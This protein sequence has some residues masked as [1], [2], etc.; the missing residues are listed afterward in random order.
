MRIVTSTVDDFI[1]N[2]LSSEVYRKVVH[3]DVTKT[4]IND[5]ETSFSVTWQAAALLDFGDGQQLLVCGADCG[6]D[7]L[8]DGGEF[9]GSKAAEAMTKRV[10]DEWLKL[11]QGR[12]ILPGMLDL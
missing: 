6:I 5:A 1:V 4:P 8:S 11:Q 9:D 2:L 12:G 7:R 10:H 3:V